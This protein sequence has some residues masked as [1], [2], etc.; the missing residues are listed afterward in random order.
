MLRLRPSKFETKIQSL[1]IQFICMIFSLYTFWPC[2]STLCPRTFCPRTFCSRT[3]CP[4][5]FCP[6]TFCPSTFC[7]RTYCPR[8]FCPRTFCPFTFCPRTFCPIEHSVLVHSVLVHYVLVHSVLVHSIL[9]HYV[10]EHSVLVHSVLEH[11]VLVHSVLVR[12]VLVL[13]V[14]PVLTVMLTTTTR[15]SSSHSLPE[16]PISLQGE[17]GTIFSSSFYDDI[18]FIYPFYVMLTLVYRW[19]HHLRCFVPV[20]FTETMIDHLEIGETKPKQTKG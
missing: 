5:T 2:H 1:L 4:R 7:P 9:E 19:S 13:I 17:S 20:T 16:I 8:T 18:W 14:S 6:P 3:F 12:S 15:M 11:S 10:L